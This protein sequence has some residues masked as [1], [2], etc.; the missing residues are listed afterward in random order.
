MRDHQNRPFA[1]LC[2]LFLLT[3]AMSLVAALLAAPSASAATSPNKQRCR[4]NY[5]YLVRKNGSY[6]RNVGQCIRYLQS[7]RAAYWPTTSN[8][9]IIFYGR[10]G[11]PNLVTDSGGNVVGGISV[12]LSGQDSF[13]PNIAVHI[14]YAYPSGLH[15]TLDRRTN[16]SGGFFTQLDGTEVYDASGQLVR[17]SPNF[18]SV[19]ALVVPCQA[20]GL[21]TTNQAQYATVTVRTDHGVVQGGMDFPIPYPACT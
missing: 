21:N 14:D 6:F 12:S 9:E 13:P 18:G 3:L 17:Y 4:H 1:R 8:T 2:K 15:G 19:P 20:L 16:S 7:G 10:P 11:Y 5:Q